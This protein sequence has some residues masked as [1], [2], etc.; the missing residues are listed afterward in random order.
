MSFFCYFLK[1]IGFYIKNIIFDDYDLDIQ[2]EDKDLHIEFFQNE[3]YF[4]DSEGNL[5]EV[6]KTGDKITFVDE[7]Y[8]NYSFVR[9][10]T[11]S[12]Y[13]VNVYGKSFNIWLTIDGFKFEG[14]SGELTIPSDPDKIEFLEGLFFLEFI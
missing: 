14:L 1:R 11:G 12:Y 13:R 6:I 9:S 7:N 10:D 4:S 8:Q 2:T 3:L 5:L